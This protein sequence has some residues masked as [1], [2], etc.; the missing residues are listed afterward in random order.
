MAGG[1]K[2]NFTAYG[3][4]NA[5]LT[6]FPSHPPKSLNIHMLNWPNWP[7][8]KLYP[9]LSQATT[10]NSLHSAWTGQ[11]PGRWRPCPTPPVPTW[12]GRR[13]GTESGVQRLIP[14]LTLGSVL[15][16]PCY[17]PR[18]WRGVPGQ[19]PGC[20]TLSPLRGLSFLPGPQDGDDSI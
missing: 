2:K 5:G 1:E 19:L 7:V 8:D 14:A 4:R 3:L 16:S 11:V 15:Q 20:G 12:E 17:T 9:S 13:R 6:C 10:P 18:G